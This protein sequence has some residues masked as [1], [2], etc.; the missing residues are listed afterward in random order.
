MDKKEFTIRQISRTNKK[1][2]ENYV[3]TRILHK[4]DDP[5]V[6]FVTQQYVKRPDGFALAELYVPQINLFIEV[7]EGQ[8]R[9][10]ITADEIRDADFE[11]A[12]STKPTR[13]RV[14]RSRSLAQINR[15]VDR[16]VTHSD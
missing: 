13:I 3:V 5:D 1:N 8:H 6:K 12:T 11:L 14:D 4:V 16:V 2:F 7:D 15:D 10:T 9:K